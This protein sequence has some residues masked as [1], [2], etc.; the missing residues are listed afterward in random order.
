MTRDMKF[1][2]ERIMVHKYHIR[3]A[4]K[5]LHFTQIRLNEKIK[6][7]RVKLKEAEGMK[8]HYESE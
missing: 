2:E 8:K 5:E 1:I 3:E 7:H 6:E 4:E